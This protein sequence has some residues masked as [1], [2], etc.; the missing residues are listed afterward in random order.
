MVETSLASDVSVDAVDTQ[1]VANDVTY[2]YEGSPVLR[3][4][5]LTLSA[6]D[7]LGLVGDN[8]AGKSTLL[9]LLSGLGKPLSG[10]VSHQGA[11]ALGSQELSAPFDATGRMLVE[12]A[13]GPSKRRIAALEQA[14]EVMAGATS[15][16]NIAAADEAYS[17]ALAK[18]IAH[19][20]WNAE[21]NAEVMLDQLGLMV[22]AQGRPLLDKKVC[23]FSGGQRARLGLALT[24]VR[25]PEILLLDEP[26]NHLDAR[27]RQLVIKTINEHPGIVVLATH[28]RDFLDAT[29]THIG[30]IIIGR[31]GVGIFRGNYTDY[32]R[33]RKHER[34]L[35]E[36]QWR[37]EEH[38]RERLT[39][40][41]EK[42]AHEVAPGRE[43][44]DR[45]KLAYKSAGGRVERQ[46]ARRV[47]SARQR[48]NKLEEDGVPKPP[49]LLGFNAPLIKAPSSKRVA[50]GDEEDFH[51]KL[52]N[53]TI[54]KR[55]HVGS[56]TIRPG[57]TVVITGPNGAG[58]TT[59]VH[60]M[61]GKIEPESGEVR[62]GQGARVAILEQE[63]R[64]EDPTKTPLQLYNLA[65]VPSS[66]D[67]AELGLLNE[68]DSARPVGKLSMGQQRRVALALI[69]ANPPDVLLLDEPT[70]HL[71]VDLIEEVQDAL[72]MSEGTVVIVTHDR[73]MIEDLPARHLVVREGEV[74]ELAPGELPN[75][76][77]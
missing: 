53:V 70:N 63:Q 57:Q 67:F 61:A 13:L 26:T 72:A 60:A 48:L 37:T 5:N 66:L 22:T 52:R 39:E 50:A 19:D 10:S 21:R 42:G 59:L 46:I 25:K 29:C 16:E 35:W 12:E 1:L 51:L 68:R 36:H 58:K 27:G 8:G 6:G 18:V 76:E 62:I 33:Y 73:R 17:T 15:E 43:M 24:F 47:R 31:P 34:Q 44:Q 23:D 30:D 65:S 45:N 7:V 69:V 54:P 38:E 11:R 40:T 14:A 77:N 4:I 32:D 20:D 49:A 9:W 56:L 71:S 55:L 41:I 28:D 3:N 2:D 75:F 64:W 74:E